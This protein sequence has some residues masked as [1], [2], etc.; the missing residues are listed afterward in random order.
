MLNISS[1]ISRINRLKLGWKFC[2]NSTFYSSAVF[3]MVFVLIPC[4]TCTAPWNVEHQIYYQT[5]GTRKKDK[6]KNT[7]PEQVKN[8]KIPLFKPIGQLL[9][10]CYHFVSKSQINNWPIEPCDF[11]FHMFFLSLGLYTVSHLHLCLLLLWATN[12]TTA[13]F[14]NCQASW[15]R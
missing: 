11:N 5:F 1:K 6:N 4:H 10:Q 8:V 12:R 13:E 3:L 9:L 2:K 15:E 14:Q 7:W